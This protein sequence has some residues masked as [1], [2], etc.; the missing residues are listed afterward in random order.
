MGMIGG[1]PPEAIIS[2]ATLI[3]TNLVMVWQV[4]RQSRVAADSVTAGLHERGWTEVAVRD[5]TIEQLRRLLYRGRVR[6][7]AWATGCEILVVA[8]PEHPTPQQQAAVTRARQLFESALLS[9]G[10]TGDGA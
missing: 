7:N 1:W 9:A 10:S 4:R 5:G 6:E 2:L 3:I 8:M